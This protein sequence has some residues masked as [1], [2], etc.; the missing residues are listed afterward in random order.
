M[1]VSCCRYPDHSGVDPGYPGEGEGDGDG[2]EARDGVTM[3]EREREI[4]VVV[5]E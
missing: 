2:G 3:R 5:S 1:S 4:D